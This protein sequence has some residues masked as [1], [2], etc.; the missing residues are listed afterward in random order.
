MIDEV[1]E[2]ERLGDDAT[3]ILEYVGEKGG[4]DWIEGEVRK[5]PNVSLCL[6]GFS[7]EESKVLPP[8]LL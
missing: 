5:S 7:I 3:R 8:Y 2:G 4:E 1:G 6:S